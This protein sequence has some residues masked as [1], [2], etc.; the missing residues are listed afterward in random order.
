MSKVLKN[1]NGNTNIGQ[2][3]TIAVPM[4]DESEKSMQVQQLYIEFIPL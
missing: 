3:G 1:G 4:C 2:T